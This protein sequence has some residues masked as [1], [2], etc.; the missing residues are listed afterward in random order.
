[1]EK[2]K[3]LLGI[4]VLAIVAFSAWQVISSRLADAELQSDLYDMSSQVGAK[5]G[6]DAQRSEDD[7]RSAVIHKAAEHGI[8]LEPQQVTVRRLV[9]SEGTSNGPVWYL[10]ADY[11]TRVNLF[12]CSL[13]LHFNPSSTK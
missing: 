1:M 5:I 8:S 3:W 7:L 2:L 11:T 6:L 12:V 9:E 10:E 4:A 13:P